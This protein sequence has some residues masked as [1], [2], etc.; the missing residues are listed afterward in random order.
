MLER[1]V[2]KYLVDQATAIGFEVRKVKW[3]GR[4]GAP[5][6]VLRGFGQTIWVETKAPKKGPKPCQI[7]EHKRMRDAGQTV[8]VAATFDQVDEVLRNA[9]S[10]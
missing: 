4:N 1:T 9:I 7:R 2:E 5:D 6:R 8:R 3:I 10:I